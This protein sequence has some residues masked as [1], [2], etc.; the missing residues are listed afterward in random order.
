MLKQNGGFRTHAL[1]N[2]PVPLGRNLAQTKD[3]ESEMHY[4]VKTKPSITEIDDFDGEID[5]SKFIINMKSI[6][7]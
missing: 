4:L 2:Q 5:V 7:L 6:L 1:Q 3:E